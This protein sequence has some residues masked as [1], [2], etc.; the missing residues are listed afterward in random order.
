MDVTLFGNGFIVLDTSASLR[1]SHVR[2]DRT[3]CPEATAPEDDSREHR[4]IRRAPAQVVA[5]DSGVRR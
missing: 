3:T 4:P 5:A 1:H 2:L